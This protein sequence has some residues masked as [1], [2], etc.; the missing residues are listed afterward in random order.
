[1]DDTPEAGIADVWTGMRC[2]QVVTRGR[3]G[4]SREHAQRRAG[5]WPRLRAVVV[6]AICLSAVLGST[7]RASDSP[8]KPAAAS[9]SPWIVMPTFSSN[10]KLGTTVGGLVAY[11][12]KFDPQSQVSMMGLSAQY[13]STDSA[14]VMAFARTSFGADHHRLLVRAL[15]G[16]IKNDYDDYLGTGEPLKSED[17]IRVIVTRYL[18]RTHEDWFVG[19][20][21]VVTNYQIVGQTALDDDF[22]D[23]LGLT[24]FESGGVGLVVEHDSRD[25]QDKPGR[26]WLLN[27]NNVAYRES[28]A[29]TEDF[30][31]YRLD[32]RGF[33]GH[34]AGHVFTVRQSN[35]W[36]VDA[37]PSAYAP[38]R[39]RGY[40]SGEYLGRNASSLEFEERYQLAER[41]T[42]TFFAGAAC[43]Y[44]DGLACGDSDN[45]Y[46]NAGAGVQYV[47]KPE[48]GLVIN[49]EYAQGK[50]GDNAVILKMGYGW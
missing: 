13:T 25:R 9:R 43:L 40:T 42:A 28:I 7:A 34:G 15:G 21:V 38:V 16:R 49:L 26:G 45:V 37:P 17:N 47:L 4:M 39:I 32:Y 2:H 44:G 11:A 18:Y 20:Q 24:G 14:T 27:L 12:R 6:N 35:Q 3:L 8:E 31:V 48:Q 33:W 5:M 23:T 22:L 46:P 30:D 1:M 10:P 19:G 36:T 41:W 50:N 29:G